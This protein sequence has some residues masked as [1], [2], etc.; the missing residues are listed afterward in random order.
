M[1]RPKG[2]IIQRAEYV[3]A[4][5]AAALLR[6]AGPAALDR[7][8]KRIGRLASKTFSRR[9]RVAEENVRRAFP[10]KSKE[11]CRAIVQSCWA[12]FARTTLEFL[13]TVE[14]PLDTLSARI[15]VLGWDH[16]QRALTRGQGMVLVT[17]HLG[18]WEFALGLLTHADRKVT[19]VA[20]ALDN[21]L[22][23]R[24]LLRAR[25]RCDVEFVD[26]RCAAHAL[27][28]TLEQKGI[29]VLVA[30]QATQ[31]HDGIV[32]PFLGRPAWSTSAPA[33]L[34]LRY[35]APIL[36]VFC[37]PA[38]ERFV[39]EIEPPI[40]PEG[41]PLSDQ[42]VALLTSAMNEV[43]SAQIRRTPEL[44]LWMHNRWKGT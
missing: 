11:E 40:L 34:S 43:I 5:A 28:N 7:W 31:R 21:E 32:V 20:R 19:I 10:E 39:V 14:E 2:R 9:T 33:R 17:A 41:L 26:R 29:V 42:N 38:G 18:S 6:R 12:H 3:V 37:R 8:G 36:C 44:W 4:Q 24:K 1:R 13:A 30:D 15:D 22:L 35:G 23:E 16:Y 27:V 25:Q